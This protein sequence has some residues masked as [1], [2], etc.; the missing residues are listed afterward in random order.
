[1]YFGVS[2]NIDKDM[3]WILPLLA[4]KSTMIKAQ[5]FVLQKDTADILGRKFLLEVRLNEN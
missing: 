2:R 5:I 4:D 3:A 1:M